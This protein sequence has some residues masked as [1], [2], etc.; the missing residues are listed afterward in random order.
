IS[1]RSG[2]SR[3]ALSSPS[4]ATDAPRESVVASTAVSTQALSTFTGQLLFS[5]GP[6]GQRAPRLQLRRGSSCL[7]HTRVQA[8]ASRDAPAH[9]L[10]QATIT[11]TVKDGSAAVLPGVTVEATS[12]ALIER[13]RSVVTDDTGQYRIVDLRPGTYVITFALPGFSTVKREGIELSGAFV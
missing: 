7:P 3:T 5:A 13:V 10:A 9:V 11:G 6:I 12:P 1:S 2:V 4:S 8:A